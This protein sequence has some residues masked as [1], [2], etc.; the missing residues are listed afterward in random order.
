MPTCIRGA[1]VATAYVVMH[2][3]LLVIV[4]VTPL[5]LEE[6]SCRYFMVVVKC[7]FVFVLYFFY[8]ETKWKT[9]E[10]MKLLFGEEVGRDF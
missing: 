7:I 5:A 3:I 6:I 9:L 8:P 2:C 4:Q 1:D 10:E